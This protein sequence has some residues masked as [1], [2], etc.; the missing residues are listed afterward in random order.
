MSFFGLP[1]N[2]PIDS[3]REA[4]LYIHSQSQ[5]S[6]A[7]S[8][9]QKMFLKALDLRIVCSKKREFMWEKNLMRLDYLYK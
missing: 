1:I 3:P 5:P 2:V 8:Y 4:F 7:S 6:E 9:L